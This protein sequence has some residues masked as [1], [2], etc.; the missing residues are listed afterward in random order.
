MEAKFD[1]KY[2][3]EKVVATHA[4]QSNSR[5]TTNLSVRG[6]S[7]LLERDMASFLPHVMSVLDIICLN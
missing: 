2:K 4:L 3:D 7:V 6:K 1:K 5:D